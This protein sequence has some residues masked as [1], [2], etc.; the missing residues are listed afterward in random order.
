MKLTFIQIATAKLIN[1]YEVV[2]EYDAK[3]LVVAK[4]LLERDAKR[5]LVGLNTDS[6]CMARCSNC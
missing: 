3:R 5:Y 6:A 2:S 1:D 4:E